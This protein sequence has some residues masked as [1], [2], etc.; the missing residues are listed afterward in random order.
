M[1]VWLDTLTLSNALIVLGYCVFAPVLMWMSIDACLDEHVPRRVRAAI[2]VFALAL[3]FMGTGKLLNVFGIFHGWMFKSGHFALNGAALLLV[4]VWRSWKAT[5]EE[6]AE[7]RELA[8]RFEDIPA[9]A[10]GEHAP[11][12]KP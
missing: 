5:M 8:A 7:L 1:I 12:D 9:A 6:L 4:L 2:F 10:W 11:E 3:M